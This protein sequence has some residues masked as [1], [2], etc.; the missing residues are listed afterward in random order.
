MGVFCES[1]VSM[2]GGR[3]C[4][5]GSLCCC[6][7]CVRAR[8]RACERYMSESSLLQGYECDDERDESDES[9]HESV[10]VYA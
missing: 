5:S 7:Y 4:L 1:N 3:E 8:A 6:F 2:E 10:S 9:E